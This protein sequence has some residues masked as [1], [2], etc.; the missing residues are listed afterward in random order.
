MEFFTQPFEAIRLLTPL[1][2]LIRI[3]L[4]VL[5]GGIVGMERGI[6]N[7][8][9]GLRTFILVSLGSAVIMMTN[10]YI[11]QI[12]GEGDPVRM[13]AQVVSGIGFLG[14]GTIMVT[15]KNQI[16]GLTTAASLWGVSC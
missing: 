7:K 15:S 14:A 10:Q 4:A 11:H 9:A 3:L 16:K 6:K 1:E 2:M 13:G 12:Y 8:L 5:L